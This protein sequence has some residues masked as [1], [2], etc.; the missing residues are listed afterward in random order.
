MAGTGVEG[1]Q[2]GSGGGMTVGRVEEWQ[3]V[4]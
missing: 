3:M 2:A 4:G 1:W